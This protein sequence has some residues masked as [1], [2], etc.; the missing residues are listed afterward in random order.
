MALRSRPRSTRLLVVTLITVSLLTIT[1]DYRQGSSGP[2][3]GLGR[4]ALSIIAPLQEGM[5]SVTRPVGNFFSAITRFPSLRAENER[6]R[7]QLAARENQE[8]LTAEQQ[9]QLADFKAMFHLSEDLDPPVTGAVVIGNSVSNSEWEVIINK[10]SDD[11]LREHMAVF[12]G[13]ALMGH[14]SSVTTNAAK[15]QLIIDPNSRV[16]ARVGDSHATGQLVGQGEEDLQ[17]TDVPPETKVSV[18]DYVVTTAYRIEGQLA[19]LDPP[20]RV[21][22]TV[23]HVGA[24]PA[25]LEKDISVRPSVNFSTLDFVLVVLSTAPGA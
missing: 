8:I 22:G 6:L 16:P 2:L 23:S 20:G 7:D 13:N 11:G 4:T 24:G 15:V 17:M 9:Q 12:A 1:L 10:G 19:G 21:I 5:T 14:V 25:A 3:A 18:G